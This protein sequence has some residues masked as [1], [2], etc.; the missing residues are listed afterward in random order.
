MVFVGTTVIN[1]NMVC[2]VE[3]TSV[4]TEINKIHA[5]IHEAVQEDDDALLTKKL[6]GFGDALTKIIDLT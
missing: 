1:S 3:H 6:N 4:A 2:L 5:Q